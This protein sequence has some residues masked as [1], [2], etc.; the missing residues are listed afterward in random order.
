MESQIQIQFTAYLRRALARQRQ[1]A[2]AKI[3]QREHFEQPLLDDDAGVVYS[4]PT[5]DIVPLLYMGLSERERM[6]LVWHV[7]LHMSHAE[8]SLRLGISVPAAQKTYQR[9]LPKLRTQL[10][11]C[12]YAF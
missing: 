11:G 7:L 4:P 2:Q 6:I 1:R 10:E 5:S 3:A 9:M 8:I 12:R